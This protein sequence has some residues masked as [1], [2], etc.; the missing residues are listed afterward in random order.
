MILAVLLTSH[1]ALN[2][3]QFTGFRAP[4]DRKSSSTDQRNH[5]YNSVH[6]NVL[7]FDENSNISTMLDMLEVR[8]LTSV[9]GEMQCCMSLHT[10][11][12]PGLQNIHAMWHAYINHGRYLILCHVVLQTKHERTGRT[13]FRLFQARL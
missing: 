10:S 2:S 9:S 11:C 1:R 7:H 12:S 8:N 3:Y 13:L 4:A 5:P 6:T